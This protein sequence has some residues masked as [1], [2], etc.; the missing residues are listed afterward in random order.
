M[1]AKTV[2]GGGFKGV[3]SYNM[4]E[5]SQMLYTNTASSSLIGWLKEVKEVRS[6]R[7]N[8]NNAVQHTSISLAPGESLTDQQWLQVA[9]V[10]LK[11]MGFD[12]TANQ[13]WVFKHDDK[14]HEHI[15][16]VIN[17]INAVSGD[18]VSDSQNY[19]KQ[20]ALLRKIEQNFSLQIVPVPKPEDRKIRISKNEIE[21]NNRTGEV[22]PK[23]FIAQA[24]EQLLEN[25]PT[26]EQFILDLAFQKI[27]VALKKNDATG[28]VK[29]ISFNYE[30]QSYTGSGIGRQFS[31]SN[32]V[33]KGLNYGEG[34][35]VKNTDA[36]SSD[37]TFNTADRNAES[38]NTTGTDTTA[39][40]KTSSKLHK[41]SDRAA[42][43]TNDAKTGTTAP[44]SFKGFKNTKQHTSKANTTNT[45]AKQSFNSYVSS[46]STDNSSNTVKN[47][48]NTAQ[49]H[50]SQQKQTT[51]DSEEPEPAVLQVTT[52]QL[53][54]KL[55]TSIKM[56]E[57]IQKIVVVA[58][59]LAEKIGQV[60]RSREL[61][62]PNLPPC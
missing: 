5:A 19:K 40:A 54:E 58:Q 60:F 44:A 31:F 33:K 56:L 30:G 2:M 55:S 15:H 47:A 36:E 7:P 32:L 18:V 20:T 35:T 49:Q 46:V 11:N 34:R 41:K 53:K 12:I 9:E 38:D 3:L 39:A 1:I 17:R 62:T 23:L 14:D 8:L 16:L 51:S 37:V 42:T 13:F 43:D 4:K 61:S 21:L 52:A 27:D 25:K 24:I 59:K 45:E 10:Y 22:T 48:V 29:G 6:L 50:Q 28:E 26:L 57:E